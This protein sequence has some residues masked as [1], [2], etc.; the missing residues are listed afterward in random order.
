MGIRFYCTDCG[1]RLN[2]KA[3]LAGKRG[4]CPHC[5]ARVQI[6]FETQIPADAPKYRPASEGNA[7]AAQLAVP[8]SRDD[9]EQDDI[10]QDIGVPQ[11]SGDPIA[12][13]PEAIWYV[14]PPSGG[15]YGPAR[16]DVMRRWVDE[17]RVSSDSMIWR[18][19]WTDWQM[20][21]PVFPTLGGSQPVPESLDI[22]RPA[23]PAPSFL[24]VSDVQRIASPMATEVLAGTNR[25][26]SLAPLI[27]LGLLIVVL[28]VVTVVVVVQ[29]GA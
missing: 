16:G 14:R 7:T 4:I 13:A 10:E 8:L 2:I 21:G 3:F 26:K 9:T 11:V 22:G 27:V 6:P 23:D 12:E 5:D 19:G 17:G 29:T 24:A 15:Q 20:A 28:L 1:R 18:E 25:K